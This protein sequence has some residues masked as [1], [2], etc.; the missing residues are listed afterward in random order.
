MGTCLSQCEYKI[1]SAWG[2]TIYFHGEQEK[3]AKRWNGGTAVGCDDAR[4]KRGR[5]ETFWVGG[6]QKPGYFPFGAVPNF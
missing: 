2:Y 3:E 1:P 5:M 6:E 4:E